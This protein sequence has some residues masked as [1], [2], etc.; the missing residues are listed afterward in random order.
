MPTTTVVAGVTIRNPMNNEER[1]LGVDATIVMDQWAVSL[2]C[3]LVEGASSLVL[4]RD[5]TI[6][7]SDRGVLTGMFYEEGPSRSIISGFETAGGPAIFNNRK[8]PAGR[9]QHVFKANVNVKPY[10]NVKSGEGGRVAVKKQRIDKSK[11]SF[12]DDE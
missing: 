10:V 12:G 6:E 7:R 1:A 4:D 5:Y 11:L 8:T 2:R 9:P 3:T